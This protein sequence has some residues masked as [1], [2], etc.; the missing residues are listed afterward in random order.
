MEEHVTLGVVVSGVSGAQPA[1]VHRTAA[2]TSGWCQQA[3]MFC[4]HRIQISP[5]TPGAVSAVVTGSLT[6]TSTHGSGR[7]SECSE[8]SPRTARLV[9]LGRQH[10]HRSRRLR[11]AV[12]AE[13]ATAPSLR[14]PQQQ[15]LGH[16]SAAVADALQTDGSASATLDDGGHP[17]RVGDQAPLDLGEQPA[18]GADCP[19]RVRFPLDANRLASPR[20]GKALTDVGFLGRQVED[21][22]R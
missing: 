6:A 11:H 19:A 16:R 4:P 17:E 3:A 9:V 12:H 13:E 15:R 10:Q 14:R 7:P 5:T 21:L 18:R 20:L 2:V 8:W 1:V 22:V